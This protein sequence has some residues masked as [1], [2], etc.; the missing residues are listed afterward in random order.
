MRCSPLASAP[1]TRLALPLA[2]L[3][4]HP[5]RLV[6][7]LGFICGDSSI[8]LVFFFFFFP[9]NG[10]CRWL[11]L[12]CLP[13]GVAALL[14]SSANE[15]CS[16]ACAET[17]A[18]HVPCRALPFGRCYF[19]NCSQTGHAWWLKGLRSDQES[20]RARSSEPTQCQ[21]GVAAHL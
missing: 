21:V 7:S 14:V 5:E 2:V 19:K 13:V 4:G 6:Y 8:L 11:P 9:L 17:C 16:P 3:G 1:L 18:S 10:N 20:L 12:I 15:R